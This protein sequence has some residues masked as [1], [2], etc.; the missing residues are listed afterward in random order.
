MFVVI[1]EAEINKLDQEYSKMVAEL[2][3]LAF[4]DYNCQDYRSYLEGNKEITLTFWKSRDD[5]K[6]WKQNSRHQVAQL[7]G[8]S[9]WYKS[10]NIIISE[11]SY[12]WKIFIYLY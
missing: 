8:K 2:K 9:D 3:E 12:T 10:V 7:K 11:I 5:I 1:F 4:S 6:N